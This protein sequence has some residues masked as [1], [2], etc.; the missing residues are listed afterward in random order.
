M[1]RSLD[2]A[3]AAAII[4]R[5]APDSAEAEILRGYGE[6][7]ADANRG[8]LLELIPRGHRLP[9]HPART[10]PS[11][12]LRRAFEVQK[13]VLRDRLR[14]R[15]PAGLGAH[16]ASL[17]PPGCQLVTIQDPSPTEARIG[18]RADARRPS[19][20]SPRTP[21]TAHHRRRPAHPGVPPRG[22]QRQ[23]GAP[24]R[25]SHSCA[26]CKCRRP[27]RGQASR[28]ASRGYRIRF[29]NDE[30]EWEQED[31]YRFWPTLGELDLHLIGEGTHKPALASP[32]RSRH[33]APGRRRNR[34][35]RL[36]A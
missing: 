24:R 3:A 33:R 19:A 8:R 11:L 27:V 18:G 26:V 1:L 12:V 6:A 2:Y 4:E 28:P 34:L 23:R 10:G 5:T 20:R 15:A 29:H 14:A 16:P 35:Q 32:R 36:G 22:D 21:R 13:A 9:A 31:P 17:P 25:E 30:R 7:W